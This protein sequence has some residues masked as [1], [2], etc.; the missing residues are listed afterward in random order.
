[1]RENMLFMW[2]SNKNIADYNTI[3]RFRSQK[4]Q[5]AFKDIFTQVI[6][7]LVEEGHL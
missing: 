6:L 3:A 2:L 7:L 5:I 4:L 1:M